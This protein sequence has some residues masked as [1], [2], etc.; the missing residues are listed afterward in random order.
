MA[1]LRSLGGGVFIEYTQ[2]LE[3]ARRH[4]LDIGWYKMPRP[5]ARTPLL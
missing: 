2:M 5:W 1:G 4:A 3:E